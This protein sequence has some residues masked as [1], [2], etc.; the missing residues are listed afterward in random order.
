MSNSEKPPL[1]KSWFGWYALILGVLL[2]QIII[3]RLLTVAFS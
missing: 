2:V 3:Y 1:F